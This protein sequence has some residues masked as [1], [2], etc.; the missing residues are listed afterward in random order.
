M[1]L[2]NTYSG[3]CICSIIDLDTGLLYFGQT[4]RYNI[5][6]K[7]HLNDLKGKRHRN[8]WLQRVYLKKHSLLIAPVEKCSEEDLNK[9]EYFWIEYHNSDNRLNGYNLSKGGD[10]SV[11]ALSED[12]KKRRADA[13][14]GKPGSL[15]G[16]KQT[17]EH[18]LNR[19]LATK[20][21]PRPM[22][23]STLQKLRESRKKKRGT[24]YPGVSMKVTDLLNHNVYTFD[25]I[26]R[27]AAFLKI[28]ERSLNMKFFKGRAMIKIAEVKYLNYKIEKNV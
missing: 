16:R 22:S 4:R 7:Q 17:K 25:T 6:A 27:C 9:R 26:R 20:G 14:R 11:N 28:D 15:K 3:P 19:S 23:E 1:I 18:I 8:I 12:A 2:E 13:R 10:F 5:R 24:T 21:I